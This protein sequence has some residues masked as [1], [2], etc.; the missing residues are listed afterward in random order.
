MEPTMRFSQPEVRIAGYEDLIELAQRG[1]EIE[2]NR[3]LDADW[4]VQNLDPDG[5]NVLR[6]VLYG[7]NGDNAG[8]L[9]PFHHRVLCLAKVTKKSEPLK[10][11]FDVA[12]SDYRQLPCYPSALTPSPR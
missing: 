1:Q 8:E 3:T 11:V 6:V 9:R 4:L 2:F 12:D 7:H 10:M 5:V